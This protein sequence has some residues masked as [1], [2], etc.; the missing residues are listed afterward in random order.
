MF[1]TD[2]RNISGNSTVIIDLLVFCRHFNVNIILDVSVGAPKQKL[3][4]LIFYDFHCIPLL[5]RTDCL[6]MYLD[7]L[8]VYVFSSV[9]LT[10]EVSDE[11][12]TPDTNH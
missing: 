10:Q 4:Y 7:F 5:V 8:E 6:F 2:V 11:L 9:K 3:C 12:L 1:E